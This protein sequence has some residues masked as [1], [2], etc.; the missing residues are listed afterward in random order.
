MG[1][2]LSYVIV[3]NAHNG[4]TLK[5]PKP[6]RFHHIQS[7]KSY[8]VETFSNYNLARP[9]NIFM[10]TSFGIKFNFQI[11]NEVSEIY[12]FDKRLFNRMDDE[13]ILNNYLLQTED[14][15]F[16]SLQPQSFTQFK[17]MNTHGSEESIYADWTKSLVNLSHSL[18]ELVERFISHIN[19]I[20]KSFNIILQFIANLINATDKNVQNHFNYIKLLGMKSLHTSW[21]NYYKELQT[22]PPIVLSHSPQHKIHLAN[23]LDEVTLKENAAEVS[24]TLPKIIDAFNGFLNGLDSANYEKD[25]VDKCIESLRKESMNNFSELELIRSSSLK[26]IALASK[27]SLSNSR[28]HLKEI[29]TQTEK[30]YNALESLATFKRKISREGLRIFQNV[31]KMQMKMVEIKSNMK[32]FMKDNSYGVSAGLI[33]NTDDTP[34]EQDSIAKV[35]QAENL[36]S[37]TVDLPLLFGFMLIEQRRQYEWFDFFTK[38]VVSNVS[39]QLMIII[40]HEKMFQKLWIK[41][42]GA[43]IKLLNV[44]NDARVHVPSVEVSLSNGYSEAMKG[45]TLA[46]LGDLVIERDDIAHY[47]ESIKTHKF[48]NSSKFASL[49]AKN[50]KDLMISTDNL[51]KVTRVVSS[52]GS[53]TSVNPIETNLMVLRNYQEGLKEFEQDHEINLVKDLRQRIRKLEDLLHQQQYSNL[54]NWPV[55]K[56][57][58][59]KISDANN[60]SMLLTSHPSPMTSDPTKFLK[61]KSKNSS[62][63]EKREM[64]A[65]PL[66]ASTT[67]DKHLDNIRLKKENNELKNSNK[68]LHESNLILKEQISKL[69]ESLRL[70]QQKNENL[71]SQ[72]EK[73][74]S[75]VQSYATELKES[76]VNEAQKIREEHNAMV[77]QL[78]KDKNELKSKVNEL[79][80]KNRTLENNASSN[81]DLEQEISDLTA[82]LSDLR[83]FKTELYS[84][85]QAKSAEFTNER[86]ELEK[87]IKDL[88]SQLERL[89]DDYE[90]LMEITQAKERHFEATI[91]S[92]TDVIKQ[93]FLRVIQLMRRCYKFVEEFSLVLESMGLLLI[94]EQN[95]ETKKMEYRIKRVKGLKAKKADHGENALITESKLHGIHS[96]VVEEIAKSMKWVESI[97]VSFE[98]DT[99]DETMKD[100]IIN[101]YEK[102]ATRLS[103]LFEKY[104]SD[105]EDRL[106]PFA[107]FFNTISFDENVQLHAL[108]T[109]TVEI[110]KMFFL[111]SIAKRFNDVEGFA[112]KLTKE[113]KS[114]TQE[115]SVDGAKKRIAVNNFSEGDLVLFLPTRIDDGLAIENEDIPIPWTAFNLDAPHYFLDISTKT[116]IGNEEWY[117]GRIISMEERLVTDENAQDKD[118]NPYHLSAGTSW[119]MV[120]TK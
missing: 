105:S 17:A 111:N 82:E 22:F 118:E 61:E 95:A 97:G 30:L 31:A 103:H 99:G 40:D 5:I 13:A 29:F 7:F 109:D 39:E 107:A 98:D 43:F 64:K 90:N 55:I 36:L 69:Q 60:M 9:E 117:V 85:M 41:K 42:F 89:T 115:K 92:A 70:E 79:E 114:K 19:V 83:I 84:N 101:E 26:A 53:M 4:L 100:E 8:L 21:K 81:R 75:E 56:S 54:S 96:L 112:K 108:E 3:Y 120:Q 50:F 68:Q 71:L 49:L 66:D 91:A 80:S 27:Q 25:S 104:F 76:N 47:I 59:V 18:E 44:K 58:G 37:M 35:R 12:V 14:D 28:D 86:N 113:I 119:Y 51:K 16:K 57:Q 11:I 32:N 52:L 38:G 63:E 48:T 110:N 77:T 33:S 20:F 72:Y 116:N 106:S 67:I 102:E 94:E 74:L 23:Y 15:K 87:K 1:R 93:L 65:K 78:A 73:K 88:I 34:R 46:F 45:S 2:D 62:I 24:S 6:V 10:L